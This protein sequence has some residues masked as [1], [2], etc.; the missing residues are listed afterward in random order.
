MLGFLTGMNAN[1]Q[2]ETAMRDRSHGRT[3]DMQGDFLDQ[4]IDQNR[5]NANYNLQKTDLESILESRSLTRDSVRQG[6]RHRADA[7]P[8]QMLAA[9]LGNIR[10]ADIIGQERELH[11]H[12]VEGLT[13]Q[14]K[15]LG[16]AYGFDEKANPKRLDAMD[17]ANEGGRITNRLGEQTYGFNEQANPKRLGILDETR[18]GMQKDNRAKDQTYEYNEGANPKRLD[19]MDVANDLNRQTYEQKGQTFAATEPYLEEM[20]RLRKEQAEATLGYTEA[21]TDY[22]NRRP[23]TTPKESKPLFGAPGASSYYE[24]MNRRTGQY[25]KALDEFMKSEKPNWWGGV[26]R[27]AGIGASVGALTGGLATKPL[28]SIP[29]PAAQFVASIGPITGGGIGLAVG[30]AVGMIQGWIGGGKTPSRE[31]TAK[32]LS[33]IGSRVETDIRRQFPNATPAQI[34]QAKS[35]A[36]YAILHGYNIDK[37]GNKNYESGLGMQES[38]YDSIQ[39]DSET[40]AK[41]VAGY[42]DAFMGGSKGMSGQPAIDDA[43]AWGMMDTE[44]S[45]VGGLSL[46]GVTWTAR[47]NDNAFALSQQAFGIGPTGLNREQKRAVA[48]AAHY[49]T[50]Q[51]VSTEA[52]AYLNSLSENEKAMMMEVITAATGAGNENMMKEKQG[53]QPLPQGTQP[54]PQG[55]TAAPPQPDMEVDKFLKTLASQGITS[56][57]DILKIAEQSGFSIDMVLKAL[58]HPQYN[59]AQ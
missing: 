2:R 23:T 30:A 38:L 51:P 45:G 36:F 39:G 27:N 34:E 21:Q 17:I 19:A 18:T 7:H 46:P 54:L 41:G 49:I 33:Q 43:K 55:A 6:M 52:D 4:V 3:L 12:R 9:D 59:P 28:G 8:R 32:M 37:D 26:V 25:G 40:K 1:V 31:A 29:H 10:S 15:R 24:G 50:L 20:A 58:T 16:Q 47:H 11:P 5:W 53:T 44:Q 56:T 48:L 42:K 35:E 57:A 13:W 14:N 22:M